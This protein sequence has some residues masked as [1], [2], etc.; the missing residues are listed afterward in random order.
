MNPAERSVTR[1]ADLP[2][3]IARLER[4]LDGLERTR[5]AGA[6]GSTARSDPA[7][8]SPLDQLRDIVAVLQ[9]R[10]T[11]PEFDEGDAIA[12]RALLE[13]LTSITTSLRALATDV[14]GRLGHVA[15]T[16]DD[17]HSRLK[18]LEEID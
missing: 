3:R 16:V 12:M 14:D 5:R 18:A 7:D 15:T 6:G 17:S 1:S 10:S 9:Q 8:A 11:Q 2:E 4:L 13:A